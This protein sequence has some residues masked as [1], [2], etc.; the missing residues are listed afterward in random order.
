MCNR[1]IKNSRR[2]EIFENNGNNKYYVLY[3][4]V[5]V[6]SVK[7]ISYKIVKDARFEAFGVSTSNNS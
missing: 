5:T 6:F 4:H 3:D 7:E 2:A 1:L